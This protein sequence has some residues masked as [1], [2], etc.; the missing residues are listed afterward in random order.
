MINLAYLT[1]LILL[2]VK[3]LDIFMNVFIIWWS[4]RECLVYHRG[5]DEQPWWM[6][7]TKLGHLQFTIL[8]KLIGY[9]GVLESLFFFF[10]HSRGRCWV[11]M[12]AYS[13]VHYLDEHIKYFG[14]ASRWVV[15]SL[16]FKLLGF[17]L[18]L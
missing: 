8:L 4:S 15:E 12:L 2:L 5:R 1:M 10:M 13:L 9:G 18:L 7:Y 6:R 14:K 11:S 3:K 16:W 17:K